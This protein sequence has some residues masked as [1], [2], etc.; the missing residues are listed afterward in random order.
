MKQL[1]AMVTTRVSSL[2]ITAVM[3]LGVQ[4][5][6]QADDWYIGAG[7]Y[8]ASTEV[9]A[10]DESD[11]VPAF[12]VGY[13]FYDGT[14]LMLSVEGGYYDLG[15][16]SSGGNSAEASALTLAGVVSIPFT[17]FFE[18]YGKAG[19]ARVDAKASGA[20]NFDDDST[21]GFAG[22]GF[23]LDILDTIDIYAEYLSFD[24]ALNSELVG[25]GIRLDF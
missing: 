8:S 23:G 24:N 9:G 16:V 5:K 15:E 4:S 12:F 22:V 7:A 11:T 25:V 3:L 14:F 6:A 19:M 18:F 20:V 2:V 21:E 1:S 17:P 10:L 13:N